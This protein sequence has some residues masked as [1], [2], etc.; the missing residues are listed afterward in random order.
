M[1]SYNTVT[2]D[3]QNWTSQ[4]W[5]KAQRVV[6]L[7]EDT[8]G[9][10]YVWGA[11]GAA[12]TPAKRQYYAGRSVC[13]DGEKKEIARTCQVLSGKKN[14]CS[15]CQWFPNGEYVLI[16]DCQGWIKWLM[17]K[18]GIVLTGGGCTS[19]YY[20]KSLWSAQGDIK[21]MPNVVCC[22]FK[23]N[24]SDQ[25][26]MEHI[27]LHIGNGQIIH[28]SGTVKRGSVSEK[29]SLPWSHYAIPNGLDGG[30]VPVTRPTLRKGAKGDDVV[31]LQTKL[32]QLGYD[33]QPY[34]ADG[35]FGNKTLEAVKNFQ[36][37]NG[38]EA[39]GVV[40]PR[41][42]EA[43]ENAS[44]DLYTV[45]IPHLGKAVADKIVQTYG[46]TMTLEKKGVSTDG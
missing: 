31:Y 29:S 6:A 35:A 7:A 23:R 34:G 19:M 27:G 3:F 1:N 22:V 8:L 33:L 11:S 24:K 13:P 26:T 32:I 18:I 14:S 28:C 9:W 30:D 46:G 2:A 41:T 38:L 42:W 36:R 16:D 43:L 45:T 40:G 5:T 12:C 4:G 17:N 25:H 39:D 10:P 21:D 20:N 44:T 15:G 37:V